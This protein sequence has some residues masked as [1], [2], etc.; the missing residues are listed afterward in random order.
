[1]GKNWER[2]FSAPEK[3]IDYS[4]QYLYPP[5]IEH[6]VQPSFLSTAAIARFHVGQPKLN[7]SNTFV[8]LMAPGKCIVKNRHNEFFA[9]PPKFD[10]QSMFSGTGWMAFAGEFMNKSKLDHNK[11]PFRGFCLWDIMA[12]DG[13]ILIGST[14]LERIAL[15][16][17]LYPKREP[18][19]AIGGVTVLFKTD[20][21]DIYRVNTFPPFSDFEAIFKTISQIDMVEGLVLKRTSGKLENM[22]R[23][24][25]NTGWA[26]KVRKPTKNYHF[27][28][29]GTIELPQIGTPVKMIKGEHK[30]KSGYIIDVKTEYTIKLDDGYTISAIKGDFYN[31]Q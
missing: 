11:Q 27:W 31:T 15:L 21:P 20:Y 16:D 13:K 26:V 2:L 5:R 9:N 6:R 7:G 25:N 28:R 29:G 18:A 24:A 30:N 19:V 10:F 8:S 12:Y 3:F 4:G 22:T 23:E 14:P 17:L 1:V